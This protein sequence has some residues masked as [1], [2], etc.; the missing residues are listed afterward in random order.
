MNAPTRTKY[1]SRRSLR[2]RGDLMR[3]IRAA[4]AQRQTDAADAAEPPLTV[5]Q[6]SIAE[7]GARVTLAMAERIAKVLGL[8]VAVLVL[9]PDDG[10]KDAQAPKADP[11][12]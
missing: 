9:P 3:A 11:Q 7:S 10:E 1:R 2:L 6:W 5:T 4:R 8:P 12:P